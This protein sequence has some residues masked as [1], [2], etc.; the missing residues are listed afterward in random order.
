MQFAMKSYKPLKNIG[1]LKVDN[2]RIKYKIERRR[3]KFPRLEFHGDSLFL[4]VPAQKKDYKALIE[5]KKNWIINKY[6]Q[7][8]EII[9]KNQDLV[10]NFILLGKKVKITF[11]YGIKIDNKIGAK[12]LFELKKFLKKLLYE[13][14]S[15]I[16]NDYAK[17]LNAKYGKLFIRQQKTK[18][19]SCS[20]K[21]NLSFNLRTISLPEELINYLVFH[22]MLHLIEKKHNRN[23]VSLIQKVFPNYKEIEKKLNEYWV[24]LNKNVWWKK[25]ESAT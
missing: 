17:K 3:I 7:I 10:G 2:K 16:A 4:I 14:I 21:R 20:L 19:S 13:K 22:E 11:D 23:F 24:I 18:W 5:S 8:N 25:I 12:N 1:Y 9:E 15:K 6:L